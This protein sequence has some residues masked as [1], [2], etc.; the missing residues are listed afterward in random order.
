[1]NQVTCLTLI[2]YSSLSTKIWGFG[3]MQFA[4]KHFTKVNGLEFYKLMGSG[5][6]TG[7][8]P[9]PD[10]STYAVLTIWKNK[11]AADAF[12]NEG[13]LFKKYTQKAKNV[14]NIYMYNTKAHGLWTGRNPF[15][16]ATDIKL[17]T[18]LIC[19]ITRAT[20][21]MSKLRKFWKYVPTSSKPLENN[22]DLIYT[23]GIGE[24]P[25][26]QMAT[27]SVW[28]NKEA[29]NAFA[30]KSHEH[31]KAV[32][33]TRDLKWYNEELFSRFRPYKMTGN[34]DG[35]ESINLLLN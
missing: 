18:E 1:M 19:V 15:R 17:D 27:F 21:K 4:H 33:M 9:W 24:V 31:T 16:A 29:I 11:A 32:K 3:M 20:I 8:N 5:K 13:D 12:I 35:L 10:W 25:I 28:K 26:I 34:W 6:G 7:F 2:K 22:T 30:Y 14:C 23:K